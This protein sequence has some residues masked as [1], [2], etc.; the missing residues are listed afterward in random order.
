MRKICNLAKNAHVQRAK[1][2]TSS[3]STKM[4][5]PLKERSWCKF[6]WKMMMFQ[7]FFIQSAAMGLKLGP[8][9]PRAK[10]RSMSSNREVHGFAHGQVD[11]KLLQRSPVHEPYIIWYLRS[12]FLSCFISLDFNL[13]FFFFRGTYSE[14]LSPNSWTSL[15]LD[16]D[17]HFA[18]G[19]PGPNFAA[20]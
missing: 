4:F 12:I 6:V 15:L 1:K 11:P 16:M 3:I 2:T 9:M 17:L 8:G 13:F 7:K 14:S 19:I 10:W 20:P 5:D 18:L